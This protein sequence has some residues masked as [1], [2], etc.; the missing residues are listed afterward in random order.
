MTRSMTLYAKSSTAHARRGTLSAALRTAASL[1]P[2]ATAAPPNR[3]AAGSRSSS[4]SS[5]SSSS[6]SSSW[7]RSC[8]EAISGGPSGLSGLPALLLRADA[9]EV[10]WPLSS[11][12]RPPPPPL[13]MSWY[14]HSP[15]ERS[16]LCGEIKDSASASR[17]RPLEPRPPRLSSFPDHRD[18]ASRPTRRPMN[19][20]LACALAI[21]VTTQPSLW[22]ALPGY[23]SGVAAL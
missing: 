10:P 14:C 23:R 9:A 15:E 7:R 21:A 20:T 11:D 3:A 17:A 5:S 6:S 18:G 16:C 13:P 4:A 22:C 1:P 8:R 12:S 19:P 2:R